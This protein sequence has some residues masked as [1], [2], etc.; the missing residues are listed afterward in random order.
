MRYVRGERPDA[1]V[2]VAKVNIA[3][4]LQSVCGGEDG[5]CQCL[6]GDANCD[7]EITVD[8]IIRA[9][10]NSLNGCHDYGDCTLEEH[11]DICCGGPIETAT[12]TPT[13]PPGAPT[14]T[15]TLGTPTGTT[16]ATVTP[17]SGPAGPCIGDCTGNGE[18]TIDELIKMVNIAL[19][20]FPLCGPTGCLAGDA[21][22]DCEI[23]VDDIVSAVNNSLNGCTTFGDCTLQDHELLCCAV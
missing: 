4:G 2:A 14:D 19:G 10:S 16:T 21:T 1:V 17:T 9:V 5:V 23:T 8:E 6:A 15:P 20:S 7:C 13:P 18:V 22:C 11:A 12:A 3:L